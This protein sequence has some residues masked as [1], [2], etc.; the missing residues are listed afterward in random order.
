[1][2]PNQA[3]NNFAKL[4]VTP[5]LLMG[6]GYDPLTAEALFYH[7]K[8][9]P[10]I[11]ILKGHIANHIVDD[12]RNPKE[13]TLTFTKDDEGHLIFNHSYGDNYS[14][15]IYLNKKKDL[16][17]TILKYKRHFVTYTP[18]DEIRWIFNETKEVFNY[19][20]ANNDYYYTSEKISYVSHAKGKG[21]LEV[22]QVIDNNE[23]Q[24]TIIGITSPNAIVTLI[25][26]LYLLHSHYGLKFFS[27]DAKGVHIRQAK[28]WRGQDTVT[29]DY[30]TTE[31][32]GWQVFIRTEMGE[33]HISLF[34]L[35]EIDYTL[36]KEA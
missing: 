21:I 22:G 35:N 33:S 3:K 10:L 9:L 11:N 8:D 1:M 19:G 4:K 18:G 5:D 7:V 15:V 26:N 24:G 17:K 30:S 27:E 12:K 32:D 28:L 36:T 31:R 20:I 16:V 14:F 25:P 23:K 13:E 2:T 6:L 34:P 29:V